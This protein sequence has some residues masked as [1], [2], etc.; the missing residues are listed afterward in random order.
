[1]T[2]SK[3]SLAGVKLR[4]GSSARGEEYL[5]GDAQLSDPGTDHYIS[6]GH[7]DFDSQIQQLASQRP[8]YTISKLIKRHRWKYLLTSYLSAV[9]QA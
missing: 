5:T 6:T 8:R 9:A 7:V 1:M 4:F 2:A 3:V